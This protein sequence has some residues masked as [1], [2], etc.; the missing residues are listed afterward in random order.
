MN[1]STAIIL[2]CDFIV[3]QNHGWIA[4]KGTDLVVAVHLKR[5]IHEGNFC[6][7]TKLRDKSC[8][9]YVEKL[10]GRESRATSRAE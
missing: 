7:A 10:R 4:Y 3:P 8:L 5:A 9:V 1:V 2:K 6:R